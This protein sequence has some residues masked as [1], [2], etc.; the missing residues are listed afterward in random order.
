MY[1]CGPRL[2]SL[3]A[4][5]ASPP[6]TAVPCAFAA[7]GLSS[8]PAAPVTDQPPLPFSQLN[9]EK[10]LLSTQESI[11]EQLAAEDGSGK[12]FCC[13]K[14]Q[15]GEDS[16]LGYGIT[17]VLECG[18]LMEKAAANVSIIHGHLSEGRA[19]A[20]SARGR[21]VEVGS[22]YFAG[23]L[24]I[25]FHPCNPHVPT[26]R[27]DVRYFEVGNFGWFGGG[28]DLTP[29]YLDVDETH[30]FHGFL[31]EL[32]D[33]FD[34]S[35][36]HQAKVA[37]DS[38]F[39]IPARKEHR[40]IGGIFFDDL[41]FFNK[42]I[43]DRPSEKNAAES[44]R[45]Q[46]FEFIRKLAEGFLPSYLPTVKR[47]RDVPYGDKER[48]WQLLR[49]GRYLEFNLLYDRGVKFGLDG[50]RIESIMVSA[51]PLIAWK[52]NVTPEAGT[53]EAEMMEVLKSPRMW[54]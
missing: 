12:Q 1:T 28:A 48:Q 10:F 21:N 49:R 22:E 54:A 43:V 42:G 4:I 29:N 5:T 40:G 47:K 46:V 31:K 37:C 52:Y 19:K 11:C 39:Y 2:Y 14:W 15:R 8:F 32:C 26:F 35:L 44:D 17:R 20:M 3:L 24:S 16:S 27:S 36:Y 38:Y 25:V 23:A 30:H 45:G 13:D 33:Q 50:G 18:S 53:A 9:F 34:P 6:R 51:P 7:F 41:E